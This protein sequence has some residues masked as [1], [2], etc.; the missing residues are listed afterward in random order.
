MTAQ[1]PKDAPESPESGA[2]WLSVA[3]A[4][5]A[6]RVS[7]RT[8]KRWIATGEVETQKDGARRV[9]R[10]PE[11]RDT[12]GDK[13]D[14]LE[15]TKGTQQKGHDT[16]SVSPFLSLHAQKEGHKGHLEGDKGDTARV[17]FVPSVAPFG[18]DSSAGAAPDFGARYMEHLEKEN[19]FLRRALEG[20]QQSEAVTKAALREA[21]KAMPKALTS[22]EQSGAASGELEQVGT[23]QRATEAAKTGRAAAIDKRSDATGP[24]PTK[25]APNAPESSETG[26]SYGDIA[27][28]LK[29]EIER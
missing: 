6:R 28:W 5:A 4:A 24:K 27:D 26:L 29:N 12:E 7:I 16:F 19:E 9:V 23:A 17:P 25:G 10:L 18:T 11:K 13:G 8:V 22:G 21:L 20:A 2:V 14:I 15:G 1:T 3:E